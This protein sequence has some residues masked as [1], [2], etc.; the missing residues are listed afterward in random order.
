MRGSSPGEK[1]FSASKHE[2]IILLPQ[3]IQKKFVKI[4]CFSRHL[5]KTF[6]TNKFLYIDEHVPTTKKLFFKVLPKSFITRLCKENKEYKR[7]KKKNYP[8][9]FNGT[10]MLN[11]KI[12]FKYSNYFK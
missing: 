1:F 2:L 10:L 3:Y 6:L 11:S 12:P 9:Y 4:I 5:L 8:N 7:K